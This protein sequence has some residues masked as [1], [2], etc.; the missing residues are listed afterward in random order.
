MNQPTDQSAVTWIKQR[1]WKHAALAGLGGALAIA[2][3]ATARD[4]TELHLLIPPFGASCVLV[5]GFPA[6]P[7]AQPK[8]VIGGHVISALAGLLAC[9]LFGYGILGVSVG[10]GL[11]IAS[12]IM[13]ETVHPPAGANPV[14]VALTQPSAMFA[15]LPVLIGAAAIVILGKLYAAG[16]AR[17][18]V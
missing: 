5:F 3:L 7:F 17:L 12:M 6:S 18:A 13:T 10:V 15:I 4:V 16:R 14:L 8:N 1:P 9:Y 11:A 2:V